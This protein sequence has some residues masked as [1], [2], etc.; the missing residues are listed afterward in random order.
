MSDALRPT[1]ALDPRWSARRSRLSAAFLVGFLTAACQHASVEQVETQA[2]V[3]VAVEEA[4]IDKLQSTIAATGTVMP[5]PGAEL[6]VVAPAPARIAEIPKAEGDAVRQGDVLVRFDIP[7]LTSDVAAKRAAIT[8]AEARLETA[9]ANYTRLT[10]LLSQGVAATR[11]VEDA[12]RQQAEAE[13]DL[14]QA[15][16]ALE[17]ASAL[18]DRAVVRAPFAGVISQR[19]HNPGDLVDAA[20]GDPV[21]KV[22]NPAQLQVV[23]AVPVADLARVVIGHAARVTTPGGDTPEPAK[24]LTRPAHVDSASATAAV[25]LGFDKPTRLAAGTVVQIEIVAEEHANALVIPAAGIVRDEGETFV[26]VAGSDNKAHKFPVAI[27]LL[28]HDRAEI[29]SGLKAGDKV[30][31]R[32]QSELPEGASI[33]VGQ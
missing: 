20:N 30:I 4:K 29:T 24:V 23:A 19:L 5:A 14:G 15:R 9:K 28:T 25:R 6:T 33:T 12:K 10:G 31:V 18:S 16:S 8:Q 1:P 17:A 13:A 32:G 11:E 2:P 3:P 7:N 26:M 27:G 22:I 21:L